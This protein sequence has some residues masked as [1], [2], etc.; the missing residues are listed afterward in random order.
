MEGCGQDP[1]RLPAP[2]WRGKLILKEAHMDAKYDVIVVGAGIAGLGAGGI[3]ARAGRKV[4]VLEKNSQVGG[5][6]A[7][8][9]KDGWVRSIGQARLLQ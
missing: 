9:T 6:A 4:L 2:G 8:F 3:L 5:R 7:T 1:Q